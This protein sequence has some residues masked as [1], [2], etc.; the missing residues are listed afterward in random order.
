MNKKAVTKYQ[1]FVKVGI[2]YLYKVLIVD[3]E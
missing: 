3:N 1:W 2:Y